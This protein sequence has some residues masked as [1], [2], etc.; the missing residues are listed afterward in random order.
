MPQPPYYVPGSRFSAPQN[1]N[2]FGQNNLI[3]TL[4]ATDPS[5]N[6]SLRAQGSI[7]APGITK[8]GA[9]PPQ[10]SYTTLDDHIRLGEALSSNKFELSIAKVPSYQAIQTNEYNQ[11]IF[12]HK[13]NSVTIPAVTLN[14]TRVNY[15]TFGRNY[16][17]VRDVPGD[18][19]FNLTEFTDFGGWQM[20]W[21]WMELV[22]SPVGYGLP[23]SD[24]ITIVDITIFNAHLDII[25]VFRFFECYPKHI[26][27]LQ[28][29]SG[30]NLVDIGCVFNYSRMKPLAI[31]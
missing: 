29:D 26:G 27:E 10:S 13:I 15:K 23:W 2:N 17:T 31:C 25:K 22:A 16:P 28:F 9:N 11:T 19:S 30:S 18:L 21:D 6:P 7:I 20:L 3:D 1:T 12:R 8:Y 14:T 4:N 5:R 24:I